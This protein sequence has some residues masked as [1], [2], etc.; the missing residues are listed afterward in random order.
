MCSVGLLG[1][2]LSAGSMVAQQ[3]AAQKSASAVRGVTQNALGFARDQQADSNK[4]IAEIVPKFGAQALTNNTASAG[5]QLGKDNSAAADITQNF[6]KASASGGGGDAFKSAITSGATETGGK[7]S[8][9]GAADATRF[10]FGSGLEQQGRTLGDLGDFNKTQGLNHD[11]YM[12]GV[13][14]EMD[15]A[16]QAGHSLATLGQLGSVVGSGMTTGAQWQTQ[17]GYNPETDGDYQ[18]WLARTSGRNVRGNRHSSSG[19]M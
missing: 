11:L 12:S 4:K 19:P 17:A 3:Q 18:S 6:A 8:A 9:Q 16:A 15:R 5:A 14:G 2:A 1:L 13:P 7:V 10:G